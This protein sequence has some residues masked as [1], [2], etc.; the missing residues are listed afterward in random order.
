MVA[1]FTGWTRQ[2]VVRQV[3]WKEERDGEDDWRWV[4]LRQNL[5]RDVRQDVHRCGCHRDVLHPCW[6]LCPCEPVL[7]PREQGVHCS[8]HH[9]EAPGLQ[10]H[11]CA[12]RLIPNAR[13]LGDQHLQRLQG[14]P[15]AAGYGVDRPGNR[16]NARHHP[17]RARTL[18]IQSSRSG[19]G[20]EG[21]VS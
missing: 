15:D 6:F 9:D 4:Y 2:P 10:G 3:T 1:D 11:R 13:S 20:A 7:H 21:F 8:G 5:R 18:V 19:L 16:R 14:V 17:R 12:L